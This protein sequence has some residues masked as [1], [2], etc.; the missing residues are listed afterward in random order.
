MAGLYLQ[1]RWIVDSRARDRRS[2]ARCCGFKNK[3][4][5][6]KCVLCYYCNSWF[7]RQV[8]HFPTLIALLSLP[9]SLSLFLS[10][11]VLFS[12]F[13]P[14]P[15][16][17]RP[18][19][20]RFPPAGHCKSLAPEYEKLGEYFTKED[21]VMIA[22]VGCGL[23]PAWVGESATSGQWPAGG[24]WRADTREIRFLRRIPCLICRHGLSQ[25][26][27]DRSPQLAH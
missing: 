27:G 17:L 14:N 21:G 24:G 19:G 22:K 4:K 10:L 26:I 16:V 23:M 20:I 6:I 25:R 13:L 2:H 8:S 7:R 3:N 1:R 12:S 11:F 9:L 15:C 5:G 18:D